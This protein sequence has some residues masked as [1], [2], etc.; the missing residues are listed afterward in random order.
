MHSFVA[1]AGH[2]LSPV[3]LSKGRNVYE[4]LGAGFTLLAFGAS[5]SSVKALHDAAAALGVP[6]ITVNDSR[7]G[8]RARL[9]AC[10]VLVRPDSFVAWAGEDLMDQ[11]DA[12]ALLSRASGIRLD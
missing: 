12:R 8:E 7:E 6:L 3:L 10:L 11:V 5:E 1:R 4:A 2:H 9:E